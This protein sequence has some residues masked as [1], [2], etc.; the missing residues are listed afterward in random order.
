MDPPP[1]ICRAEGIPFSIGLGQAF[2]S[3][4]DADAGRVRQPRFPISEWRQREETRYHQ[5]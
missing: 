3:G 5:Q 1:G 2:A 4:L